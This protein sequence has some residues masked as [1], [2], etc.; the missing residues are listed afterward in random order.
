M[1]FKRLLLLLPFFALIT[2]VFSGCSKD[3]DPKPT[4]SIYGKIECLQN[5]GVT[6][7]LENSA[8]SN[9][10]Y[11]A[12]SDAHGAFEI[13]H[14][15]EGKYSV[16]ATKEGLRWVLMKFDGVANHSDRLIHVKGS[17]NKELS[18]VMTNTAYVNPGFALELTDFNGNPVGSTMSIPRGT[19]SLSFRLYNG[20]D[21]V[22]AWSIEGTEN[23]FIEYNNPAE[24]LYGTKKIFTSFNQKS[25]IVNPGEIAYIIGYIDPE[26][27][28]YA[29]YVTQKYTT[30][31]IVNGNTRKTINLNFDF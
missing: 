26:I 23:C 12:V 1:C 30:I 5:N 24:Y 3:D 4:C 9:D 28:T 7:T 19:T 15:P 25:G 2:A 27:Y 16:S 6:V 21:N 14:V 13:H 29:N 22:Q 10:K 18:I 31:D 17:G 8:D 11:F 20:S